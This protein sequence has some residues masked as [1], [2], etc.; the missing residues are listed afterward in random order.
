MLPGENHSNSLISHQNVA[1][2]PLPLKA[3]ELSQASDPTLPRAFERYTLLK[4]VA[5]GGMGEVYLA[6][7]GTIEGAERP[8]MVKTIR[9]DHADDQSFLA[10]FLDEARIQSQLQH[11]GVAQILEANSDAQGKPFVVVE[12]V[13]GRNLGEVRSRAITLGVRSSW[14]EGVA[15]AISMAEALAHVHER[16]D[17]DGNPLNIVH[18]DLS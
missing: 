15:L 18:R 8:C 13:E 17:A 7:L 3:P 6:A 14:A 4:C 1:L 10:R 11:P 2:A 12:Y 16:T 9:R 5:K